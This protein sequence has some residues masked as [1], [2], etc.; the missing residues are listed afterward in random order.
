VVKTQFGYHV[1]R[2]EERKPAGTRPL[3]EVEPEI[4]SELATA[5]ADSG[6]ARRAASLARKLLAGGD[7]TALAVAHGGLRTSPPFALSDPMPGIGMVPG[8]S[9]EIARTKSGGW[10]IKP[11][12][13]GRAY[14]VVRPLAPTP[15]HP[16]EFTDVKSRA[17][18]DAKNAKRE[19]LLEKKVAA[20]RSALA[21]GARLDSLAAPYGG[22]KSSGPV[23]RLAGFVPGL[24]SEP[25][26]IEKAFGLSAG[27]ASDTLKTAQGRV[28]VRLESR[29]SSDAKTFASAR[30][31]L[32]EELLKR[33]LDEWVEA[34]K[35]TMKIEILSRD[36]REIE[37]GS[38]AGR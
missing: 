5:R 23:S 32:S 30:E 34:R 36:L 21:S 20:I 31:A 24:G 28:W 37:S 6:A 12:R 1:I 33:R 18:E 17:I 14:L 4:R 27:A 7:A 2:V 11:L 25:R 3:S 38:L 22:L 8:L 29:K 35:K 16:A 19:D 15:E 9:E 10:A 26:V 13:T